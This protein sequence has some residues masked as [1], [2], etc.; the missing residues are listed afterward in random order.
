MKVKM[1]KIDLYIT[2]KQYDFLKKESEKMEITFSD[3][4]RRLIDFYKEK[5]ND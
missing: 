4:L 5:K 2:H 1:R 3:V